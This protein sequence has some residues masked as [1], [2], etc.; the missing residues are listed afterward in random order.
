MKLS[1]YALILILMVSV[2]S[3]TTSTAPKKVP[4][5]EPSYALSPGKD[6]PFADLEAAFAEMHGTRKSG[7][8]LLDNN[9]ESLHQRLMLI[10]KARYSLDI[11]YY[12]WYGDD[13]GELIFK[14]TLDAAKRGVRVRVITDDILLTSEDENI[15]LIDAHPNVE[16]RIFNPWRQYTSKQKVRSSQT[17]ERFNYRMHNKLMVA[18]NRMAILG[19]RNLGDEYFGLN[20]SFNFLD[21]DV[22][23]VGPVARESSELFDHFWNNPAVVSASAFG[24]DQPQESPQEIADAY[25]LRFKASKRLENVPI[26]R[27]NWDD[28]LRPYVKRLH[29]GTSKVV[30][31]TLEADGI[32]QKMATII[33]EFSDTATNELL[34]VNAYVI[35]NEDML[36]GARELVERGVKIKILTNSLA[37]QDVPAVNSHYGPWRKAILDA[38][39]E[40]Y[41]LRPDAAIKAQADTPPV[42]SGFVG[43]HSKASVVD[44]SRVYIG[45]FNLDPR[46]RDFNTEMGVLIDSPELAEELAQLAEELME[47]KNS[48]QVKFNDEGKLIWQSGEDIRTRQPA[49]SFWQRVMDVFFKLFPSKYF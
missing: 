7:F 24:H 46:A 8:L 42:V 9:A 2:C 45:S 32:S 38:G 22:I 47:P 25:L 18:D 28:I 27:Q 37:S 20:S 17:L 12:L 15:A 10:D 19:G 13:S 35:P 33:P 4:E 39:I 16:V 14:R 34:V 21:I 1:K 29:P 36:K 11:K 44:R 49:Q 26:E 31:D 23:G 3:C 40:L 41:E 5:T 43:L 30:Y 6:G 48:W